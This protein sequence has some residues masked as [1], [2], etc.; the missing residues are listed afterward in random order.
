MYIH[1]HIYVCI[2]IN[3]SVPTEVATQIPTF[4]EDPATVRHSIC[5][6][7]VCTMSTS[8]MKVSDELLDS[9]K[10][11]ALHYNV[12]LHIYIYVFTFDYRCSYHS[13]RS[14]HFSCTAT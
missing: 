1:I 8:K 2:Y 7:N 13:N 11:F 9:K 6:S 14:R 5:F 12:C 10:Y 4:S 3:K